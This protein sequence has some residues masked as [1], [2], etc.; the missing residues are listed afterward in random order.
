MYIYIAGLSVPS[1]LCSAGYYCNAG[2]NRTDP[3]DGTMG[4]VCP[5]GRYCSKCYKK[6]VQYSEQHVHCSRLIY[7]C[8]LGA[9]CD[10]SSI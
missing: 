8:E 5:M 2:S 4:A 6:C 9:R 7:I 3:T 1:G 10:A